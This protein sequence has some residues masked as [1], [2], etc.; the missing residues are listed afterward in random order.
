MAHRFQSLP[1]AV[2]KDRNIRRCYCH[3]SAAGTFA[4]LHQRQATKRQRTCR[5]RTLALPPASSSTVPRFTAN[6]P[7]AISLEPQA[8]VPILKFESV[9]GIMVEVSI[10]QPLTFI[11]G[12]VLDQ[13]RLHRCNIMYMHNVIPVIIVQYTIHRTS[14]RLA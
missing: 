4:L 3:C 13:V 6:I 14:A 11:K 12:E 7:S 1:V 10:A 5:R 9:E 8:R 2:Y